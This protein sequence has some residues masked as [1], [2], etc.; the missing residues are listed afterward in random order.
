MLKLVII[1]AFILRHFNRTRDAILKTNFSDYVN[2]K[3]L[4]QYNDDDIL[5]SIAFYSKNLIPAECNYQIYD[6]KLLAIIRY[7][8]Y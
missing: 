1:K 4:S 5:H 2:N 7:L 8:K 3:V 6:K